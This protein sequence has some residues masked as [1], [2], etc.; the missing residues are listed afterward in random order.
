LEFPMNLVRFLRVNAV[1]HGWPVVVVPLGVVK[2]GIVLVAF[3]L[4]CTCCTCV[5]V[6]TRMVAMGPTIT[7]HALQLFPWFLSAAAAVTVTAAPANVAA[8]NVLF[9]GKCFCECGNSIAQHLQLRPHFISFLLRAVTNTASNLILLFVF[10]NHCCC[11]Y[12]DVEPKFVAFAALV[13]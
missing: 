6:P 9:V 10:G 7:T 11:N 13:A 4:E 5:A 12:G 1:I 2:S 8:T 3:L